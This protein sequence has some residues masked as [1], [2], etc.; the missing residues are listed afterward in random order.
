MN[1]S[2]FSFYF[3]LHLA[4]T[5]DLDATTSKYLNQLTDHQGFLVV[6]HKPGDPV[7]INTHA[8]YVGVETA[9]H[10]AVTKV[11]RTSRVK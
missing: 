9:G 10:I 6:V 11:M 5:L 2:Y 1:A 3:Y 4:L 7:I 8:L